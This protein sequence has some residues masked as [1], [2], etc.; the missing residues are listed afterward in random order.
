V[1][2]EYLKVV[3]LRVQERQGLLVNRWLVGAVLAS[4]AVQMGI[5]YSP[6]AGAFSAVPLGVGPWAVLAAVLTAGLAGALVISRLLRS[7]MGAL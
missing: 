5:I 1:L 7:R 6:L 3:V 4:L 2:A